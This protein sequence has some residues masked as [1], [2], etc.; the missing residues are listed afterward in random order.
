MVLGLALC[1]G[2]VAQQEPLLRQE[3]PKPAPWPDQVRFPQW[4]LG[5]D[6]SVNAIAASLQAV[7]HF[8]ACIADGSTEKASRT[9]AS[10]FN[11]SPY[12]RALDQMIGANRGCAHSRGW[13]RMETSRL[14]LAGA[15]A[16]RLIERD[17]TPINKR[18]VLAAG[19]PG[20][21][22]FSQSDAGA[23]CAVRSLPDDVGKLL[24]TEPGSEEEAEA[25]APLNKVVS[26]CLGGQ[27]VE[28]TVPGLRAILSTAAFRSIN[29]EA[30]S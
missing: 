15:I 5:P 30:G 16:E 10:D 9:L 7:Q 19:R 22:P 17:P 29:S 6:A 27:P 12:R 13:G 11:S 2:A 21:Q 3:D 14:L 25:A 8:G 1:S 23:I 28:I 26:L 4:G 18:L 24:A 20:V